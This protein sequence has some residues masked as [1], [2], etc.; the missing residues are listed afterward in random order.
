MRAAY[1][2][3]QHETVDD[4]Q[5]RV[6]DVRKQESQAQEREGNIGSHE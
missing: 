4:E 6:I 3:R 1:W 2:E 5:W